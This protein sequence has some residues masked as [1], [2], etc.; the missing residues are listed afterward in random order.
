MRCFKGLLFIICGVILL[1]CSRTPDKSNPPEKSKPELVQLDDFT[2]ESKPGLVQ[3]SK[4]KVWKTLKLG[5]G[6]KDG[7][8]FY[9]AITAKKIRIRVSAKN[10]LFEPQFEVAAEETEINII[11]VSV[12]E[13]GL[14]DQ[15]R[16]KDVYA[17]AQ[18]LGLKLCPSEVG[19][20]LCLQHPDQIKRE[21]LHIGMAVG[22]DSPHL[23][24][25]EQDDN[26]PRFFSSQDRSDDLWF[27]RD[28]FVFVLSNK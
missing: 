5:T 14:K 16:T 27:P 26:G 15:T 6:I 12:A 3:P 4:F 17:R 2:K 24:C 19:P 21:T 7:D 22:E 23:F 28:R 1:G 10:I 25:V 8:G 9:R 11:V 13:L 20:Q 18:E